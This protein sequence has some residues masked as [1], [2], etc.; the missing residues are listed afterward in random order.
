MEFKKL[1]VKERAD[2]FCRLFL[3]G[4]LEMYAVIKV[5]FFDIMWQ[6]CFA[7]KLSGLPTGSIP[8]CSCETR[9]PNNS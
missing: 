3:E 2:H 7:G 4:K 1:S 6:L 5:G 8:V 9:M